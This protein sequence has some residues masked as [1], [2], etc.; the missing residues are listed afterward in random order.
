NYRAKDEM[1]FFRTYGKYVPLEKHGHGGRGALVSPR[2]SIRRQ[3]RLE[4]ACSPAWPN[5]A[6]FPLSAP[7]QARLKGF[8]LSLRLSGK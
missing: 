4:H 8:L 6:V 7:F 2:G 1:D 5:I 3:T